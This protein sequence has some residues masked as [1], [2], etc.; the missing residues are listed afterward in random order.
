MDLILED[1]NCFEE[2]E[3]WHE[4]LHLIPD[5]SIQ[6]ELRESWTKHDKSSAEKWA[7]LRAQIKSLPKQSPQRVF[8]FLRSHH[9]S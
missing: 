1:Q 7:D 8:Q 4:L 3:G 9:C 2:K 6:A 5:K